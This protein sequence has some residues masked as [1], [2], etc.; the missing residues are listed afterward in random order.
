MQGILSNSEDLQIAAESLSKLLKDIQNPLLDKCNQNSPAD[1]QDGDLN[2]SF[3]NGTIS[4]G[5]LVFFII[6]MNFIIINH[7]QTTYAYFQ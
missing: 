2:K 7:P 3:I 5:E 4:N 1:L 6:S